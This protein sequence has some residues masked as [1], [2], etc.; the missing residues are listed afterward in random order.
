MVLWGFWAFFLKL[1]G[2]QNPY[3]TLTA[4][5]IGSVLSV[6]CVF[7]FKPIWTVSYPIAFW[8]L[9]AGFAG[10]VGMFLFLAALQR[11]K[12]PIVVTLTALYPLVTIILSV[13]ILRET[14]T[15][16]Q[17]LGVALALVAIALIAK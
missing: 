11:G 4:S 6:L 2:N 8:G 10:T 1:A 14:V 12:T 16:K 5:A 3:L 15:L 17:W 7:P 9:A 13:S